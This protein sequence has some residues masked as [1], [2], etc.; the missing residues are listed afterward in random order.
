M[1]PEQEVEEALSARVC[2]CLLLSRSLVAHCD[3]KPLR[4][5]QRTS[6]E[7]LMAGTL[8][9]RWM[10]GPKHLVTCADCLGKMGI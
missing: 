6:W 4:H 1:T 5:L 3:G 10:T 7:M 2:W 9:G 8:R